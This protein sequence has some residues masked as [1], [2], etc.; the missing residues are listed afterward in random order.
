MYLAAAETPERRTLG[1]AGAGGVG[2]VGCCLRAIACQG[3]GALRVT[4]G[5]NFGGGTLVL[6]WLCIAAF[7]V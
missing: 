7:S 4:G 3:G 6:S 5:Q 2:V 1:S